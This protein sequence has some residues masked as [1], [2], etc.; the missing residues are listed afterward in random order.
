M[1]GGDIFMFF[2]NKMCLCSSYRTPCSG[3]LWCK[4]YFTTNSI[5]NIELL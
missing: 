3:I 2:L 1:G 5:R 4:R